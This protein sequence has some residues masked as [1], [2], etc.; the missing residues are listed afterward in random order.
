MPVNY[1]QRTT[2]AYSAQGFQPYQWSSFD[3]AP[4]TPLGK[5]L[6]ECRIGVLST[7][8]VFLPDQQPFNPDRDDFTFRDIPRS[9]TSAD[10]LINHNNYDHTDAMQDINCVIP[11]KALEV[12]EKEGYVKGFAEPII[13]MMGRV[14]RRSILTREMCPYLHQRFQ[15]MEVDAVLLIPV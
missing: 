15:E 7:A 8:G 2:A 5:P 9:I 1:I 4:F 3:D 11:V 12:L 14:F 10:V 6:S 13:T